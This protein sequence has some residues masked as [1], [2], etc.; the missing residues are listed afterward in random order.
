MAWTD[1]TV[2]V[3]LTM[4]ISK[5]AYQGFLGSLIGPACFIIG[6]VAGYLAFL[7][8]HNLAIG[9]FIAFFAPFPLA[10]IIHLLI[11]ARFGDQA[12]QID[13]FSRLGGAAIS[14]V[15][16]G[17]TL[18]LLLLLLT[19][20]PL[21]GTRLEPLRRDMNSS[22]TYHL[23]EDAIL[24]K[25]KPPKPPADCPTGACAMSQADIKA[26][27]SDQDVDDLLADERVQ[28]MINDP[29]IQEAI[30]KKDVSSLLSNPAIME[31]VQDPQFLGKVLKVYPKIRERMQKDPA[32]PG[33]E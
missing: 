8:T 27:A 11:R 15:W 17:G 20:L 28:R 4:L 16:G 23:L 1:I 5:G 19:L 25:K 31:L 32:D 22:I 26:L 7:A 13:P 33:R 29:V 3:I 21:K 30:K 24:S 14:L 6:S 2:C 10:W 18:I 12:P 9:I